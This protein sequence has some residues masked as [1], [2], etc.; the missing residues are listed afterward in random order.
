MNVGSELRKLNIMIG[1]KIM[2]KTKTSG[3]LVSHIQIKILKYL[4]EHENEKIYQKDL[5]KEFSIRRSTVSGIL[6]TME[7]NNFITRIE[8]KNDARTKEIILSEKT[9]K[10]LKNMQ[11]DA[12]N[13]ENTI[14][15]DI[16]QKDLDTFIKV[17]HKMQENIGGM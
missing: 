5:E 13:F 6:T 16:D 7:K 9:K 2:M 3:F 10:Q 1:R 8:S 14:I 11:K 12:L 4:Y 15:K 17:I